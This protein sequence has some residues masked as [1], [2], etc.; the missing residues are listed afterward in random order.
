ML[1]YYRKPELTREIIDSE[2]WLNT[3]DLAMM[4]LQGE[5]R[6]VGRQKDTIVLLGGENVEPLPIEQKTPEKSGGDP[7][8]ERGPGRVPPVRSGDAV[9]PLTP[10]RGIGDRTSY[11]KRI[12]GRRP[13]GGGGPGGVAR[14][15]GG[16]LSRSAHDG[17]LSE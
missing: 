14:L 12:E 16:S 6:I 3:G 8:R 11:A 13:G 9:L 5:I 15:A 2:G 7:D 4:T 10:R 1:G 17:G